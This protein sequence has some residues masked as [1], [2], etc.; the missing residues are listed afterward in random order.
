MYDMHHF[1]NLVHYNG[2]KID[3]TTDNKRVKDII[4]ISIYMYI[5]F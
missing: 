2:L 1:R 3:F 5:I 4:I